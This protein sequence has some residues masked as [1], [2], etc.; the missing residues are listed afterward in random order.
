MR[1]TVYCSSDSS[2]PCMKYFKRMSA[3]DESDAFSIIDD[4]ALARMGYG[5][6]HILGWYQAKP[7]Y[8]SRLQDQGLSEM[9][10]IDD[11]IHKF[12]GYIVGGRLFELEPYDVIACIDDYS[13]DNDMDLI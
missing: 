12:L 4:E 5:D 13:P 6:H 9:M 1:R 7:S 8:Y 2:V 10:L 3:A 11:G